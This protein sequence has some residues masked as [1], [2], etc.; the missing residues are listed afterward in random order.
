MYKLLDKK[1]IF[2]SFFFLVL[3]KGISTLVS[4]V[5]FTNA[6]S[7]GLFSKNCLK[8]NNEDPKIVPVTEAHNK[9]CDFTV[10]ARRRTQRDDERKNVK[11]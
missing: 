6:R 10:L 7:E 3:T 8:M 4:V 9:G 2:I 11:T 1:S 5:S